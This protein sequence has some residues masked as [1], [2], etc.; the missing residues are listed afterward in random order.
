MTN[1]TTVEWLERIRNLTLD[2]VT[3]DHKAAD[4]I[5]NFIDKA[6]SASY[7]EFM[8]LQEKLVESLKSVK[9][10]YACFARKQNA[11]STIMVEC[12]QGLQSFKQLYKLAV[13]KHH[14]NA[15]E[16]V[17]KGMPYTNE[18]QIEKIVKMFASHQQWFANCRLNNNLLRDRVCSEKHN[19]NGNT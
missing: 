9:Y 5:R 12:R 7:D 13:D 19:G 2:A 17:V 4:V 10:V 18:A 6:P 3:A 1:D 8:T 16:C 11:I 15:A 14:L